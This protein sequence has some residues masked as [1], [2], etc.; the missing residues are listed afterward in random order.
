MHLKHT[1]TNTKLECVGGPESPR[2]CGTRKLI[3]ATSPT[4]IAHWWVNTPAIFLLIQSS[5][6]L[7]I[8]NSESS[9]M[10]GW[11]NSQQMLCK[12]MQLSVQVASRW[13]N[14]PTGSTCVCGWGAKEGGSVFINKC[15]YVPSYMGVASVPS[16]APSYNLQM[17]QSTMTAVSGEWNKSCS[18]NIL[19]ELLCC[20]CW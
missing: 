10:F 18:G 12:F 5:S 14:S 19:R 3:S 7:S 17:F 15:N 13:E 9:P 20:Y 1:I 11:W 4:I 6:S 16:A 8:I 2:P